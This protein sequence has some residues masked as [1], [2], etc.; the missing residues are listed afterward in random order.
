[1]RLPRA[2]T[3]GPAVSHWH[4]SRGTHRK[5]ED[6]G[7]NGDETEAD[8]H[9]QGRERRRGGRERMWAQMGAAPRTGT[10][11]QQQQ[12]RDGI[13]RRER[14]MTSSPVAITQLRGRGEGEKA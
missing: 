4:G 7:Q 6:C 14:N 2:V 1:M 9:H 8:T 3:G 10:E 12:E 5:R 11:Q 13:M